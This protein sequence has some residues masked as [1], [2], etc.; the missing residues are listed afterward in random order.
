MAKKP[1]ARAWLA[2]AATGANYWLTQHPREW[3]YSIGDIDFVFALRH[4]LGLPPTDSFPKDCPLK[5]CAT[6]KTLRIPPDH[7]HAC[8]GLRGSVVTSRHNAML[9]TVGQLVRDVGA[10]WWE[11]PR[12][13]GHSIDKRRPDAVVITRNRRYMIDVSVINPTSLGYENKAKGKAAAREQQ[14]INKYG[15]L[16]QAERCQFVPFVVETY[17]TVG[18]H[19]LSFLRALAAEAGDMV[20]EQDEDTKKVEATFLSRSLRAA[21]FALQRGNALVSGVGSARMGAGPIHDR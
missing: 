6:G 19:A 8:R 3:L 13:F 20:E 14:K 17:G 5:G 21:S 10:Y 2:R 15:K 1:T 11:E 7:C 12:L 4:R 16:A 9:R 18:K